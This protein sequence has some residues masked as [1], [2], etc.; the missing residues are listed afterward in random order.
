MSQFKTATVMHGRRIKIGDYVRPRFEPCGV[1]EE[2]R[3]D[4]SPDILLRVNGRY[5]R[6]LECTVHEPSQDEVELLKARTSGEMQ[7]ART[8][9][10]SQ[11]QPPQ[12]IGRK[13]VGKNQV[14]LQ[15]R[16]RGGEYDVAL[17]WF[18]D[19]RIRV[20]VAGTIV[21]QRYQEI[22]PACDAA[23]ERIRVIGDRLPYGGTQST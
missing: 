5:R 19:D 14:F 10:L 21:K 7:G 12:E 15:Y 1:V 16:Y 4:D 13:V 20:E 9:S 22:G 3:R 2:I 11:R 17:T 18:A 6:A 23:V 8:P